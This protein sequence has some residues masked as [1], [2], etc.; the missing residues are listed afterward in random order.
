MANK[1]T[2]KMAHTDRFDKRYTTL[3]Y[4]YRGH[5]YEVIKANSWAC[6]SDYTMRGGSMTLSAQHKRA[7]EEIDN[8]IERGPEEPKPQKYEGS[9]QEGFDLFWDFVNS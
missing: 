3:I 1:A 6:S 4:E 7:Q 2:F 8:L 5:E 9:A